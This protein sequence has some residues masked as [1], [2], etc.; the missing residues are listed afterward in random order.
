MSREVLAMFEPQNNQKF[1]DLTFRA[2]GHARKL[3]N[4]ADNVTIYALDGDPTAYYL[5]IQ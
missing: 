3:L 4:A 2:G 1:H 5:A